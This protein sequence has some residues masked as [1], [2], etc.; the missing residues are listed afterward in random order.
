[1][2]LCEP[3]RYPVFPFIVEIT[4]ILIGLESTVDDAMKQWIT[5][6]AGRRR[7]TPQFQLLDNPD[8]QDRAPAMTAST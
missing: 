7:A 5:D 2:Q 6:S 8:W 3:V 1:M 4:K